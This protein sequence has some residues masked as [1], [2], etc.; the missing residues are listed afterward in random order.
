[1]AT[2]TTPPT[3]EEKE[4]KSPDSQLET[5][6]KSMCGKE[7]RTYI[8]S[9][10]PQKNTLR[11]QLP[12]AL[13]LAP[14]PS[15][16]VLTTIGDFYAKRG[17]YLD[18]DTVMIST[19]EAS[20]LVLESFLLMGIDEIDEGV[21]EEAAQAAVIWRR[22][23]VD[24]RGIKKASVMD[25]RGLLLLIGC[26]GIPEI[27]RNEDVRDLIRVSNMREIKSA[28][29]KSNV[30]ME[31]IPEIIEGMVKNKLEVDAVDAVYTFGVE[32]KCS[33][34]TI[35]SSF[36]EE[37]KES[38]KRKKWKSRGS[39][40]VVDEANKRELSTMKSVMECLEAHNIDHSKL[41]ARFRISDRIM[42][43][44]EK[45]AREDQRREKMVRNWRYDETRLP[46][47]FEDRQAK[48]TRILGSEQQRAVNHISSQIPPLLADGTRHIYGYSVS[49]P[50]LPGPVAGPI[51]DTVPGSY[52]GFRLRMPVDDTAGQIRGYN[53]Q[54]YGWQRNASIP[55]RPVS[56]NYGYGPST[57]WQ[58]SMGLPHTV[59]I[60]P[61]PGPGPGNQTSASDPYQLA[62]TVPESAPYQN[63]GFSHAV[64]AVPSVNHHSS[65]LY[66]PGTYYPQDMQ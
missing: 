26:F 21:K 2:S 51:L 34:Y 54:L 38:L 35:L 15:K 16:L 37:L 30:L 57:P 11:E 25:A 45:I 28:L 63:S 12:N 36:L 33:P 31:K 6:C 22:R 42:S 59:P 19:R 20:V 1:M 49:P 46:R 43:L 40:A 4:S 9:Q 27:F 48:R 58:G 60:G 41:I 5:L 50:V 13:K 18:K 29:R 55:E 3:S 61:G 44:E 53:N 7:L 66:P 64:G 14:N 56:H 17:K 32:E 39:H 23:F 47:R 52:T 65:Y 10:L 8:I 24:E 62:N